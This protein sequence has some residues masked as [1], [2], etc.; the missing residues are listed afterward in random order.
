LNPF[1]ANLK[2]SQDCIDAISAD[3]KTRSVMQQTVWEANAQGTLFELPA[4]P[5]QAAVGASYRKNRFEFTND[6]LTTQ[7]TSFIDQAVGLYPSGY[8]S[9]T[10][11]AKEVYGELLVPLLA[12][13]RGIRK[14]SLELGIRASDYNT[15][16]SSTTW[17]ALADWQ[18][19]D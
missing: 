6:T 12:D 18:V 1:D 19:T 9:G 2:V 10:I 4:G 17:K 3:I 11:I 5:L 14:L 16:G 15:T 13:I 7:G 8:S